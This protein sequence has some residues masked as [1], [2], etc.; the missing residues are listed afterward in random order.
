LACNLLLLI[1]PKV[2]REVLQNE[3]RQNY[4]PLQYAST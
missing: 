3:Q 2:D 4:T 1:H